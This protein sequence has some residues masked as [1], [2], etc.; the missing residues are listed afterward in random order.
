M[1]F[2]QILFLPDLHFSIYFLICISHKTSMPPKETKERPL[3]PSIKKELLRIIEA[4]GTPLHSIKLL[5]L[6]NQNIGI[7]GEPSSKSNSASPFNS[8]RRAVQKY[9]AYLKRLTPVQYANQVSLFSEIPSKHTASAAKK[10]VKTRLFSNTTTSARD[11]QKSTESDS[12]TTSENEDHENSAATPDTPPRL[13]TKSP[14]QS[15]LIGA[16]DRMSMS[17]SNF[18]DNT[19]NKRPVNPRLFGSPG[20]SPAAKYPS[21]RKEYHIP[22]PEEVPNGTK[23][24]PYIIYVNL[25]HMERN[26]GFEVLGMSEV[27]HKHKTYDVLEIRH[28]HMLNDGV[29]WKANICVEVPDEFQGRTIMISGPSVDEFSKD[30]DKSAAKFVKDEVCPHSKSARETQLLAIR[31]NPER[32]MNYYL[33]IF[34][35]GCDLDNSVFCDDSLTIK[36]FKKDMAMKHPVRNKDHHTGSFAIWRIA[37][38]GGQEIGEKE[39]KEVYCAYD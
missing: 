28:S 7:L 19:P 36:R 39:E 9:F 20:F 22:S 26:G 35:E 8:R 4:C 5:Q 38:R 15:E 25:T 16:L 23:E 24:N 27:K 6:C 14:I 30:K 18:G 2:V 3:D 17:G 37:L 21:E 12:E 33:M 34:P 10:E 11:S 29:Y 31:R 1:L 32:Q 13:T